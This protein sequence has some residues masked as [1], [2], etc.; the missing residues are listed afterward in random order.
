MDLEEI[1]KLIEK[2]EDDIKEFTD[3]WL[4]FLDKHDPGKA[5]D[6]RERLNKIYGE[7]RF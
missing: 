5:F 4:A 1:H 6:L 7:K 3:D 2:I